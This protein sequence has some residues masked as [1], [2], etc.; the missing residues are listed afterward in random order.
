[1]LVG[2]HAN[3]SKQVSS[4]ISIACS[5]YFEINVNINVIYFIIIIYLTFIVLKINWVRLLVKPVL[6]EY[7]FF[8]GATGIEPPQSWRWTEFEKDLLTKNPTP[9]WDCWPPSRKSRGLWCPPLLF[10]L[11]ITFRIFFYIFVIFR[12]WVLFTCDIC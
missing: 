10:R 1:M 7:Q 8:H 6:S 3:F 11:R 12:V 5:Q 9:A 2:P 4:S